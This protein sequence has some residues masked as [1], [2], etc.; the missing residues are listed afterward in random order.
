MRRGRITDAVGVAM[1]ALAALIWWVGLPEQAHADP[2]YAPSSAPG[3]AGGGPERVVQVARQALVVLLL[4]GGT[5][6]LG[7]VLTG[8]RSR[9]RPVVVAPLALVVVGL[10]AAQVVSPILYHSNLFG[11]TNAALA[12]LTPPC[13]VAA[14]LVASVGLALLLAGAPP[15][16]L[17]V[18]AGLLVVAAL[19]TLAEEGLLWWHVGVRHVVVP[20][21]RFLL[22]QTFVGVLIA[23]GLVAVAA[24]LRR[25]AGSL[26]REVAV[27]AAV[28]WGAVVL[29]LVVL[30]P[31]VWEA[32][33]RFGPFGGGF[34][35]A[36]PFSVGVVAMLTAP[37]AALLAARMRAHP[38]R[39]VVTMRWRGASAALGLLL[40]A[41]VATPLALVLLMWP[42]QVPF[43]SR[44][45]LWLALSG[46]AAVGF[47]LA[48][49]RPD[50]GPLIAVVAALLA[51]SSV[52]VGPS[53][54]GRYATDTRGLLPEPLVLGLVAPLVVALA[55]AFRSLSGQRR[56]LTTGDPAE[57]TE[58]AAT[59]RS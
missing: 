35:P 59:V 30:T 58:P 14:T 7:A 11:T 21:Y 56:R 44:L 5:A 54:M 41:E 19:A 53:L 55:I 26:A 12:G 24:A 43:E 25:P 3:M 16:P 29:A 47:S 4:T 6:V 28:L 42:G 37:A 49:L 50:G 20:A 9:W 46:A 31:S 2:G 48:A 45:I 17:A 10:A 51:V 22:T 8:W 23:C 40:F 38:G 13:A 33:R 27:G 18:V 34:D 57:P 1:V 32:P 52:G 15:K 36:D 39:D